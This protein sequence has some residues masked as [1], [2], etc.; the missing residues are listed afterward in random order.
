VHGVFIEKKAVD[1]A[2]HE[3]RRRWHEQEAEQLNREHRRR[4]IPKS[5][6]SAINKVM[7]RF[8]YPLIKLP[9][10]HTKPYPCAKFHA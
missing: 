5:A 7:R 2:V 1:D 3:K 6:G 9:G 10:Y 4:S 8:E